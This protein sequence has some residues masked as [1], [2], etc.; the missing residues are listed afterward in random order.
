MNISQRFLLAPMAEISHR[1]L[2][3]LIE[4]FGGC[5]EYYT[6]MI[7]APALLAGGPFEKWYIDNGPRPEKLV[8][9]LVGANS[10]QITRAAALL[11]KRE[12][13]GIDLNMGCSAPLIRKAGAGVAWMA[14]ADR[15]GELV[16]EVRKA[17]KHRLSVK[18]RT[19]FADDFEYLMKFCRRLEAEGVDLIILHPRTATE[20]FKRLAK[21]NYVGA[22]R[23]E[24]HIPVAG[25]GDIV[26]VE[27]LIRRTEGC[28]AVMV[29]R[30][31]V[32]QPW[33]FA[34]ARDRGSGIGDQ[35]SL[36]VN[37]AGCQYVQTANNGILSPVPG[38]QSL[39]FEETGLRFIE[40]LARWQPPEFHISRARRFFGFFCDNLKWGNYLKNLLNR[41]ETLSGME[42]VWREYFG[43]G[44]NETF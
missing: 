23:Q 36:S 17:V 8:F 13:A 12:C 39:F 22:L 42:R 10:S 7:S 9:Q 3:E 43:G 30:A 38:P 2:R 14:S 26:D 1:A 28:D 4:G 33:I 16:K 11:D 19:G 15:A 29:G 32:R 24:L 25:N 20:K 37:V 21:W 27:G 35:G 5:D 18:I 31:A 40:L 6:E 41:E 34:L 44:Q